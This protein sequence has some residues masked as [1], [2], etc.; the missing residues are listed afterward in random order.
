MGLELLVFSHHHTAEAAGDRHFDFIDQPAALTTPDLL[1]APNHDVHTGGEVQQ[2]RRVRHRDVGRSKHR[3]VEDFGLGVVE[4]PGDMVHFIAIQAATR[5]QRVEAVAFRKP[6]L[7]ATGSG[8]VGV[9]DGA[10]AS[11]EGGFTAPTF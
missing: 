5:R 10:V 2:R 4:K 11:G 8:F 1:G 7:E 6:V 9:A 3:V